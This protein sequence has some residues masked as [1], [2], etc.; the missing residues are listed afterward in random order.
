MFALQGVKP[1]N[2]GTNTH[3]HTFKATQVLDTDNSTMR[4]HGSCAAYVMGAKITHSKSEHPHAGTA[5]Q[6]TAPVFDRATCFTEE[7]S[8]SDVVNVTVASIACR[9]K[10]WVRSFVQFI[11]NSV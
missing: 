2:V 5:T 3:T 1:C 6:S 11:C 9:N 4:G 10:C 7:I 8:G